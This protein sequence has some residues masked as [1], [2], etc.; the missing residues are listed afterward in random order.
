M[1]DSEIYP[2]ILSMFFVSHNLE[3]ELL[4]RVSRVYKQQQQV[5]YCQGEA[6]KSALVNNVIF[7]ALQTLNN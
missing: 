6:C 4:V 7:L 2:L 5:K 1:I 3:V